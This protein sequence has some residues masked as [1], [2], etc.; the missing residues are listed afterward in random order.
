VAQRKT[1]GLS[2]A[3]ALP[4]GPIGWLTLLPK[5]ILVWQVQARMV[6]DIAGAFGQ[7]GKLTPELILH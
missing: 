3:A 1:A 7:S 6:A 2:A 4:P 5:A